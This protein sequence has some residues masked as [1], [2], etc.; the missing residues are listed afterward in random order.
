VLVLVL[1]GIS[2]RGWLW[3]WCWCW[4]EFLPE[5][6]SGAGAGA[7]WNFF[8]FLEGKRLKYTPISG[9][10][11]SSNFWNTS[12]QPEK[13]PPSHICIFLL[14]F[15]LI[16][17]LLYIYGYLFFWGKEYRYLFILEKKY[18]Y[19]LL[20]YYIITLYGITLHSYILTMIFS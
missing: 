5:A 15:F 13:A 11:I 1:A 4:L 16:I 14:Y 12:R 19:I 8:Q 2:S 9:A 6:G 20:H 3:C 17:T 10:G 18:L 7:G